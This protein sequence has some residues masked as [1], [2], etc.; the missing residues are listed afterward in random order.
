MVKKNLA[1]AVAQRAETI[2]QKIYKSDKPMIRATTY[3]MGQ[4]EGII[5][6][7]RTDLLIDL[8]VPGDY[9]IAF[10]NEDH[11]WLRKESRKADMNILIQKIPYTEGMTVDRESIIK[12]RNQFGKDYISTT[13]ENSYM[14]TDLVSLKTPVYF[15]ETAIKGNYALEA[16]GIWKMENGFMGGAFISY[17]V[18]HEASQSLIF[19][20][21]FVYA[22]EQ[23]K[24]KYL[25]GLQVIME[26]LEFVG[27]K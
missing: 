19:M 25:Q 9:R 12:I 6:D 26:S 3:S 23:A 16:R 7:L 5:T 17:L 10:K 11:F 4:A 13:A 2:V 1:N 22:P 15:N 20:D 27:T 18:Y 21:G 14:S 8:R 24:R